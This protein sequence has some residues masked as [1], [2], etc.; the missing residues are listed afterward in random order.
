MKK[1]DYQSTEANLKKAIELNDKL[2]DGYFYLGQAYIE[3]SIFPE[4]IKNLEKAV[5]L[6]PLSKSAK[7]DLNKFSSTNQLSN[8]NIN[9]LF[10][11][12]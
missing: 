6:R 4:A 5:E 12:L 9:R 10:S 1:K 8:P 3:I 2:T 11:Q 7:N